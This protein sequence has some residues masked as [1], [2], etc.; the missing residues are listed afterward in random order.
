M[1]LAENYPC[2][3]LVEISEDDPYVLCLKLLQG[4]RDFRCEALALY[5]FDVVQIQIRDQSIVCL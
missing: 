3:H 5:D 1:S 4:R 2:P